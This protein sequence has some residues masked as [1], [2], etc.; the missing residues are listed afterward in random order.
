MVQFDSGTKVQFEV[1]RAGANAHVSFIHNYITYAER[2][3]VNNNALSFVNTVQYENTDLAILAGTELFTELDVTGWLT[4]FATLSY[5]AGLD[6]SRTQLVSTITRSGTSTE[7]SLN[8]AE[9]PLPMMAPLEGRLGFRL[10]EPRANPRYGAELAV[11]IDAAQNMVASSLFEQ[12]TSGF[13]V[14]D[15]RAYWH[16]TPHWTLT[17]GIENMF[18]RTYRESYDLLTGYGSAPVYAFDRPGF[19]AYVGT[20]LKF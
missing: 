3:D 13:N 5:V 10:H 18:S 11:R 6:T 16:V 2:P 14:W 9:E 7:P 17:G 15:L 12:P 1:F 8:N 19:N 4:T 20:E